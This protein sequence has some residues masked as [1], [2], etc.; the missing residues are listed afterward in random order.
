M[1][2][3]FWRLK[4]MNEVKELDNKE[5]L[6]SEDEGIEI[7]PLEGLGNEPLQPTLTIVISVCA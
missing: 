6:S 1:V 4:D 5:N 3:F 2:K 7:T